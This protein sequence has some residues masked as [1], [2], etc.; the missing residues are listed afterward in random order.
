MAWNPPR[1]GAKTA[2]TNV[3][4]GSFPTVGKNVA[5]HAVTRTP[6]IAKGGGLVRKK[7][8]KGGALE[9]ATASHRAGIQEKLGAQ[10][11]PT[12]T[13]YKQNA[14]EASATQRNVRTVPSAVG[15]RD[16]WYKRAYGQVQQ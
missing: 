7:N 4:T 6:T 3:Q 10:L 13:L 9:S 16:F 12:A 1:K 8:S 15:N 14:A 5:A 11:H 2:P